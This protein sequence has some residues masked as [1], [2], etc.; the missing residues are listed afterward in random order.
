MTEQELIDLV[1]RNGGFP[2]NNLTELPNS[3]YGRVLERITPIQ[4][5]LSDKLVRAGG[6]LGQPLDILPFIPYFLT[7]GHETAD[8]MERIAREG[9]DRPNRAGQTSGKVRGALDALTASQMSSYYVPTAVAGKLAMRGGEGAL[10]KLIGAEKMA[11]TSRRNFLKGSA[12]LAGAG[13]IG[14]ATPKAVKSVGK[15]LDE[16]LLGKSVIDEAASIAPTALKNSMSFADKMG[17]LST[18]Q[19]SGWFPYLTKKVFNDAKSPDDLAR[20]IDPEDMSERSI[21]HLTDLI[22]TKPDEFFE[23]VSDITKRLQTTSVEDAFI[24]MGNTKDDLDFLIANSADPQTTAKIFRG[25]NLSDFISSRFE[26]WGQTGYSSTNY[27]GM[28]RWKNGDD[29]L[30]RPEARTPEAKRFHTLLNEF[31]G[32]INAPEKLKLLFKDKADDALYQEAIDEVF[33]GILSQI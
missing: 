7:G 15:L 4:R 25:N 22:K 8:A 10:N 20:F 16:P 31:E 27:V 9:L 28:P 26:D 2:E 32:N 18:F 14:A 3:L 12:A 23:N 24:K 13:A 19:N 17:R 1:N 11:D 29:F 6:K 33:S 30:F 5:G 21:R